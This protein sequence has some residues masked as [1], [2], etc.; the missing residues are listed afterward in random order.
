[1]DFGSLP[2]FARYR[3]LYDT[4]CLP[5]KEK[6]VRSL[7]FSLALTLVTITT[8]L[9]DP[10][11]F[12][13]GFTRIAVQDTVP[14]EALIASPTDAAE[15]S[16]EEGPVRVS[17]GRDAPVA[18]GA[19]FPI[20][21]FSHGGSGAGTPMVHSDLLLLLARQGFIVVAP[22]HPATEKTFVDRPRQVHKALDA[23]LADPRFSPRADAARIG[24]AG[25]SFGGAVT[26]ITAGATIDLAHLSAYCRDHDD[27]RA[28]GG[29]PTDGSWAK[30]PP[31]RTSD[32]VLPLKALVLL[33][34]Y[35]APF[36]P[37]GLASLDR[38][39]LIYATLQTD[40]RPEGNALAMAKAMARPPHLETIPG[41]HFVFIDPC[42]P[43]LAAGAAEIC[44]DPP[45]VDRAAVHQRFKQEISDFLRANL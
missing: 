25:F 30:V 9:A 5:R 11:S 38:P 10:P 17:A 8:A 33:E 39:A 27:Q 3:A 36:A 29:I 20:L 22:F 26:L 14:F 6:R 7:V 32:A 28:C 34:P 24:M 13:A 12:K 44:S 35:G 23:M 45:G 2:C 18:A 4:Q 40:L 15:A 43:M 1:M 19:R 37:A 21:L 42:S 31:G 16:V 41:N